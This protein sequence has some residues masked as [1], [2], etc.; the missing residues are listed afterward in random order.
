MDIY[1]QYTSILFRLWD[2]FFEKKNEQ[3]LYAKWALK[4]E[5]CAR[6]FVRLNWLVSHN[7]V[8]RSKARGDKFLHIHIYPLFFFVF[9]FKS[10][11]HI[12]TQI[13]TIVTHAVC[14]F[15]FIDWIRFAASPASIL[16]FFL[17]IFKRLTNLLFS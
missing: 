16:F 17:F 8:V 9:F 14:I 15:K 7:L 11:S 13:Y 3:I 4:Y 5:T 1:S 12:C 2:N 10:K 6:V